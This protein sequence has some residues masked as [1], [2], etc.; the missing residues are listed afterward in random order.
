MRKGNLADPK[1][2][3]PSFRN[4]MVFEK[5]TVKISY[6]LAESLNAWPCECVTHE[7]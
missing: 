4:T 3:T 1:S 2:F 7:C 5:G 6:Q